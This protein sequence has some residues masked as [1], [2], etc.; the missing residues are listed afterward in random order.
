MI[1]EKLKKQALKLSSKERAEL[2]HMLIDS[3]DPE[4][5]FDSEEAWSK[6]LKRR[7]DQYEQGESSAKPWSEV[8]KNAQALLD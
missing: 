2:A 6:E 3:L 7:I 4:I 1:D 8:K 5:D